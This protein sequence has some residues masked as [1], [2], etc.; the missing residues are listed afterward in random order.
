ML[1]IPSAMIIRSPEYMNVLKKCSQIDYYRSRGASEAT[2]KL[3][4]MNNKSYGTG[5]VENIIRKHFNIT[6]SC[7]TENDG[8]YAGHKIEIK[9]PRFGGTGTYFI[10]HIKPT[11]T[12]DFIL[13]ALLDIDGLTTSIIKKQEMIPF[14]KLQK[15]EGFFLKRNDIERL[16]FPIQNEL[17]LKDYLFANVPHEPTKDSCE[18]SDQ[19]SK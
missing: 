9:A 15:G 8:E 1:S 2:M 11:H 3:V 7:T 18:D 19:K 6:H 17:D 13:V 14:L 10:Q 5:L 12:F 16:G 4:Q